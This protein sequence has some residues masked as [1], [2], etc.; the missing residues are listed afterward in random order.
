MGEPRR[1]SFR[2]VIAGVSVAMLLIPQSMAYA[3]LAGLPPH[4]GLYA[5][6]LPPIAAAF[7]AS[8]PYLQTGPV[9]LTALLTLGALVPL[10]PRGSAEYVA[11]AILLALV[12]GV[13]RVLVG[14]LR[15]GGVSYL[16]SQ[17]VLLAFT[18]GAAVLILASQLP[19]AL[20]VVDGPDAGVLQSA[21]W[22]VAHPG[23]WEP[24]ALLLTAATVA[25]TVWGRKIHPLFPGV[26]VAT[27]GGLIYS[28]AVG[29][30]GPTVGEVPRGFPTPSLDLPWRTLPDLMVPGIV[31]ALVGFAEAASIS[32]TFAT[33]DREPWDPNKEFVGQGLAN[34]A[35]GLSG[36]FPVGGSF[37]RSS[38]NRIAGARSRWSGAVS[39]VVVLAFLPFA[40]VLAPLPRAV[41]SAIV[42]AAVARLIQVKPVL[43]IL[44]LSKLQGIVG[45]TTF[46]FT[47]ALAP[48]V[49]QAVLLGVVMALGVHA[50]RE[51]QPRMNSWVEGDT[52]HIRPE[53]VLWFGSAP[54]LEEEA[55]ALLERDDGTTRI[56]FHLGALGRIDYTGALGLKQLKEDADRAGIPVEFRDIPTHA[57]RIMGRV[58]GVR[59]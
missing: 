17:P 9:A 47:L 24:T 48:R 37:S 20:G 26:L 35:S 5:A 39:G 8:S 28:V 13:T 56:V 27:V 34:I 54:E 11:L 45:T 57:E 44:R 21:F 33:Q 42:I 19:G 4:V 29:Y 31:I 53:G 3:E 55:F 58:L 59:R 40:F 38:I 22:A 6:A 2:D 14:V 25:L 51:M 41:L 12:V 23:S 43:E 49:D 1:F 18:S 50:W 30:A 7:A 16:M 32:R 15:A 10:A 52:L 46:V 36:G